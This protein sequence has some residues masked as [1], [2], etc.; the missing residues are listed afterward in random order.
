MALFR[1]GFP[2]QV[3]VHSD[4]GSQYCSKDYRDLITIY[5]L[6]QSM[7]RKEIAGTVAREQ[8]P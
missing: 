3:I 6:K 7:S 8:A 5:N 4:R 2:E 1:R